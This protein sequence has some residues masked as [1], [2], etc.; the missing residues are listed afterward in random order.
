MLMAITASPITPERKKGRV[1]GH[2]PLKQLVR[3]SIPVYFV[4][5]NIRNLR[6]GDIIYQA[7]DFFLT[8]TRSDIHKLI[9]LDAL[10]VING[11]TH[12]PEPGTSMQGRP[13]GRPYRIAAGESVSIR[14][15]KNV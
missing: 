3:I 12:T 11:C 6:T 15:G 5:N 9:A 13:A 8:E 14:A 7:P 10:L 2:A 1:I 4:N